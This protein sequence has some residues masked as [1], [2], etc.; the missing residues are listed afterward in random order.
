MHTTAVSAILMETG[1]ILSWS[2]CVYAEHP[3]S[4]HNLLGC[5]GI[6]A[7]T[8]SILSSQLAGK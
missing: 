7:N 6:D 4:F 8:Q 1:I 3:A 2:I 5:M